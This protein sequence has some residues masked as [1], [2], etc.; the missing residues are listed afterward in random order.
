MDDRKCILMYDIYCKM[1]DDRYCKMMDDRYCKITN[2]RYCKIG[3]M[4]LKKMLLSTHMDA[5]TYNKP[6]HA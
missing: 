4:P 3:L 2:D 5:C 6:K 1:M